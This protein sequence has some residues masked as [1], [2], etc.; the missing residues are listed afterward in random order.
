[1][2]SPHFCRQRQKRLLEIME[3]ERLDAVFLGSPPDVYYF[4]AFL[5][6][7]M[8]HAGTIITAD[9]RSCLIS[10]IVQTD[11]LA[12]DEVVSFDAQWMGTLRQEQP[13]VVADRALKWLS[14][15]KTRRLGLDAS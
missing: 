6:H 10:P 7:S 2:L 14:S 8:H 13:R 15:R 11:T 9:G 3:R 12:A 5:P 4:S 1:M